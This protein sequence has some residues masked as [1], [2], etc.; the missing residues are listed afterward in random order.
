MTEAANSLRW[1]RF[2]S[3]S[4]DRQNAELL[5]QSGQRESLGA[6]EF[7]VL[8]FLIQHRN[9]FF[10]YKDII[11]KVWDA[12]VEP[13]NAEQAMTKIRRKLR[14]LGLREEEVIERRRGKGC[15]VV[16]TPDAFSETA[17]IKD[18][19]SVD[20]PKPAGGVWFDANSRKLWHAKSVFL[21]IN[22]EDLD[23]KTG[24]LGALRRIE[25]PR[26]ALEEAVANRP[27]LLMDTMVY[28]HLRDVWSQ[29][30]KYR[31]IIGNCPALKHWIAE[32]WQSVSQD[33]KDLERN[34]L[35]KFYS[36][37]Q[38]PAL[39]EELLPDFTYEDVSC[40]RIFVQAFP[41]SVSLLEAVCAEK[42]ISSKHR[43]AVSLLAS[44]LATNRDWQI[45][46]RAKAVA[47]ELNRDAVS[48][49]YH[50]KEYR[51]VRQFL[52]AAA[53]AGEAPVQSVIDFYHR[54]PVEWE[55]IFHRAYYKDATDTSHA[56]A[57]VR[58]CVRPLERDIGTRQIS[59]Y[60]QDKLPRNLVDEVYRTLGEVRTSLP[61]G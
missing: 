15:R 35:R 39:E 51:V 53:E 60:H 48:R 41:E 42:E 9:D 37:M 31:S 20:M 25:V 38:S 58:K 26:A 14:N 5:H 46:S 49:L 34:Q 44:V 45:S 59:L 2:D 55:L 30:R 3:W 56:R 54:H 7:G 12:P 52:Y 57:A 32:I 1:W 33:S 61:H 36:A 47:R 4:L 21:P 11:D 28:E 18:T 27:D 10:T 43:M 17:P 8:D 24:K 16:L 13:N 50:Y 40:W 22:E 23:M 19:V 6:R 29:P